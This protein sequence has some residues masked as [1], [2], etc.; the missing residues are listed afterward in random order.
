ME[1]DDRTVILSV[2]VSRF[3]LS[4]LV[5]VVL[6]CVIAYSSIHRSESGKGIDFK[7]MVEVVAAF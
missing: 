3:A 7:V 6:L 1:Y 4:Y 2:R 5:H